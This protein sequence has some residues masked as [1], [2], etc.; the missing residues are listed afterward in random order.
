M[1]QTKENLLNIDQLQVILDKIHQIYTKDDNE[2]INS[3]LLCETTMMSLFLP[4]INRYF[5]CFEWNII[6]KVIEIIKIEEKSNFEVIN[7][8]TD[9]DSKNEMHLK[10]CFFCFFF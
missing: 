2:I 9:A 1:N 5:Q 6:N 3:A 8:A 10:F 4:I 7:I